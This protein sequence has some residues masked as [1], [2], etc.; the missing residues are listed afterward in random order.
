M[1][2]DVEKP[3]D[4]TDI[5]AFACAVG[6]GTYP[7]MGVP[8]VF[9][10]SRPP[11]VQ[12]WENFRVGHHHSTHQP[13][14]SPSQKHNTG[15]MAA[16][17]AKSKKSRQKLP[18]SRPQ[19]TS[20]LSQPVTDDA[21]TSSLLTAFSPDSERFALVSLAVDKHR[22]R[23]FDVAASNVVAEHTIDDARVTA[24][25]WVPLDLS[26]SPSINGSP[27]KKRKKSDKDRDVE[28]GFKAT[29]QAVALGLSDGT[30]QIFSI[31][32]SR[33]VRS[34]SV[35]SSSA[36]ILAIENGPEQ[37][38]TPTLWV[39]DADGILRLWDTK[40]NTIIKTVSTSNKVQ[41]SAL[42]RIPND[43][44]D[45]AVCI[46]A[47]TNSIHLLA[48]PEDES[49]TTTAKETCSY[50]GHASPVTALV[51]EPKPSTPLGQFYSS[52]E[53]DRFVY[54]WDVPDSSSKG[55]LSAS[56][57]VD[58]D[59][60]R[61]TATFAQGRKILSVLSKSGKISLVPVPSDLGA[62]GSK[63]SKAQV[64]TLLPRSS[65]ALSTKK[66]GPPATIIDMSFDSKDERIIRIAVGGGAQV[67]FETLVIIKIWSALTL[68]DVNIVIH[69]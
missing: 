69:R 39:S 11:N 7:E 64:P 9:H 17:V 42:A 52:A 54:I 35:P 38:G 41:Y 36:A 43:L 63:S 58:S 19:T 18:K 68:T 16:V 62:P 22:L 34:L 27:K 26:D 44:E 59:V 14:L 28:K 40:R 4:A 21:W 31:S 25:L 45:D 12:N 5:D 37:N 56:C 47:A 30:V 2:A 60:R 46:L 13:T 50:T 24:L 48:I 32:H 33:V 51:W 67:G 55:K 6:V 1:G 66:N 10:G 65:I 53:G 61:V 57:P 49:S 20:Q 29:I 3:E 23:I 15:T 8:E